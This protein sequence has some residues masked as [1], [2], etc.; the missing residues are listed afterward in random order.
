[1]KEWNFVSIGTRLPTAVEEANLAKKESTKKGSAVPGT[2]V[3]VW[4]QEARMSSPYFMLFHL[5]LAL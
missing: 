3:P 2:F 4:K 1:M 5:N